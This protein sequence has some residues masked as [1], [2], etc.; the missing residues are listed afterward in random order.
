MS[1]GSAHADLTRRPADVGPFDLAALCLILG[2]VSED[3]MR[4][5]PCSVEI[6]RCGS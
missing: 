3:V 5:A 4:H 6:V 2:N 1:T